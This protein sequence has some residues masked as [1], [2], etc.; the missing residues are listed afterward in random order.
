[1]VPNRYELVLL[2]AALQLAPDRRRELETVTAPR[3]IAEPA[4]DPEVLSI[5]VWRRR[6]T[7]A[8]LGENNDNRSPVEPAA[9]E[10][11]GA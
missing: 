7:I 5:G 3:R 1:V 4:A 2:G 8:L 11:Q 10:A 9:G 6:R